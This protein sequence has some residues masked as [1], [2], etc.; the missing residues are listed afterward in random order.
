M[1]DP[2][3]S[4]MAPKAGA[5]S[6]GGSSAANSALQSGAGASNA[7]EGSNAPGGQ[8]EKGNKY[9]NF[10][11]NLN[12]ARQMTK[13][14]AKKAAKKAMSA[15]GP[16]GKALA[17]AVDG[18]GTSNLIF[19][20]AFTAA[21]MK[22]AIDLMGDGALSI[23]G[24]VGAAFFG[25]LTALVSAIPI[26]GTLIGAAID[27]VPMAIGGGAWIGLVL[28]RWGLAL[29][30]WVLLGWRLGAYK[31]GLKMAMSVFQWFLGFITVID[32]IPV[33]GIIPLETLSVGFGWALTL[34]LKDDGEE[35]AGEGSGVKNMRPDAIKRGYESYRAKQ[36][37]SQQA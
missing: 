24:S 3:S 5:P 20:I 30:I 2:T 7:G 8:A 37:A 28:F 6:A 19:G 13:G 21:I 36:A 17:S 35:Q 10:A 31:K 14:G 4:T 15:A 1:A 34:V 11:R 29:M 33:I 9:M 23:M 12:Q 22:D 27:L 32:I 18:T 16:E 25:P 26:V